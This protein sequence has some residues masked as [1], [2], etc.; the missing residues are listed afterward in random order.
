MKTGENSLRALVFIT[1][2]IPFLLPPLLPVYGQ[3]QGYVLVYSPPRAYAGADWM[4]VKAVY[5][6]EEG[7]RLYF[8]VEYYGAI[9]MDAHYARGITIYID[10]DRNAQ[11]GEHDRARGLGVD[12]LI[13]LLYEG[14]SGLY[15]AYL[16]RWN[17]TSKNF[18]IIR[19]LGNII[20]LVPGLNYIEIWVDKQDI[21][22][23]PSGVDFYINHAVAMV[24]PMPV[25][26]TLCLHYTMD[27]SKKEIKVDGESSDWGAINPIA[28]LPS[29]SINPPELE[30]SSFYVANDGENLYFRLDSRDKPTHRKGRRIAP[31][32]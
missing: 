4:D 14:E 11:T 19:D 29:G 26:R 16:H 31:R 12:Y 2:I 3:P 27:S 22:Y 20:T 24:N 18:P 25:E 17:S 13:D 23:T 5:M 21:G 8:Y 10:A 15:Y 28:A 30:V 32:L 6:K 9:P 1:V 7:D